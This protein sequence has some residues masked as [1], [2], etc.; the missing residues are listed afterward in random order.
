[1]LSGRQYAVVVAGL[2]VTRGLLSLL[3]A[4]EP[5][6]DAG[7]RP[8]ATQD[9]QP[10]VSDSFTPS[11]EFQDW[12][13]G[14]V[15]EQLPADYEKRKNWGHTAKAFDGVSIRLEG[16][17]LKTH[18][19][20]KDAN[21]GQWQMYRIKLKDPAEKFD[22]RVS[23]I[24]KLAE[25]KVG[26]D[27][28]ADAAVEVFGRQ[29]L[30]QHGVQLYSVSAEADARVRLWASVEV[31]T[32]LDPTRLPPDVYLKPD[33]TAARFEIPDLRMRRIGELQGPLVRSLSHAIR[34]ALE[35]KLADDNEKIVARLNRAI[36]K[37][38]PK[39]KLSLADLMKT[40]FGGLLTEKP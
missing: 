2:L 19:K 9:A 21:D 11:P 15:R 23:N 8:A 12:V 27:L 24:R 7:R 29:S 40:R 10:P 28:A 16:G 36:D 32:T 5:V 39:L 17:R 4:G 31:A 3:S 38:E 34:E 30:W 33:V 1:M 18:R 25:G 13:T 6:Q 20:F 22:I 26:L 37:Q 14:L 35:E